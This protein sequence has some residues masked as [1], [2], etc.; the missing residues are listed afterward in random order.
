MRLL[1][2]G[3]ILLLFSCQKDTSVAYDINGSYIGQ[4]SG[5][6]LVLDTVS[7]E[8]SKNSW[9]K[10]DTIIIADYNFEDSTFT[11]KHDDDD[12]FNCK[13]NSETKEIGY[14]YYNI[15]NGIIRNDSITYSEYIG[16]TNSS[17]FIG[18]K[19]Y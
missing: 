14:K 11:L 16:N 8:Y 7:G 4:F 1:F 6:Y 19:N 9:I 10:E 13:Y 3:S 18:V 2:V 15:R 17:N 12:L 5:S